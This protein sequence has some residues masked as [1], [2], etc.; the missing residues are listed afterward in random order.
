MEI[1]LNNKKVTLKVDS[2]TVNGLIKLNNFTFEPL[3]TKINGHVVLKENR[4]TT[5]IS[6]GDNVIILHLISGG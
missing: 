3:V 1:T 4:D 5:F 6:T 2:I